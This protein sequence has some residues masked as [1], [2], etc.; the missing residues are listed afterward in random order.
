M[1]FMAAADLGFARCLERDR[2]AYR[3]F[4]LKYEDISLDLRGVLL[5]IKRTI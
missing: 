5:E 2:G 3:N 4:P 1:I